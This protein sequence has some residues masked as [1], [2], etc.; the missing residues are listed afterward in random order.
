LAKWKNKWN[1]GVQLLIN[2]IMAVFP[3]HLNLPKTDIF[4]E[5]GTG[6]GSTAK[7]AYEHYKKVYTMDLFTGIN[8]NN[9]DS[10][11]LVFFQESS[12]TILP[13]ILKNI[14]E[15]CTFWLDAHPNNND[16]TTWPL[17]DELSLIYE[18]PIKNHNIVIDDTDTIMNNGKMNY[19]IN[20]LCKNN[21]D[22]KFNMTII[23]QIRSLDTFIA[24]TEKITV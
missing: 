23:S 4:I 13:K 6:L 11:R 22:Y 9:F 7:L 19:I 18:H 3:F 15:R 24:T 16:V 21:P 8:V 17:L 2:C 10:Q 20:G 12:L 14:N 1:L 5:T